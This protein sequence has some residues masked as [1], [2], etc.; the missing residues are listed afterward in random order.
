[1]SYPFVS[2]SNNFKIEVRTDFDFDQSNPL[3]FHYLFSYTIL[4][5][6]IGL[7]S[8]QLLS[9]KWFIRDGKGETRHVEGPGVIGQTPHFKPGQ[10]FEY[11]SFCPL[12]TLSGE[13]WGHFVMLSDDNETFKID[14]PIFKF[15]VPDDYIDQY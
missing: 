14:T 13:M 7:N 10:A 12:P 1:M 4:I 8:A 3:Q 9:R 5:T 15:K 2:I 11:S 6:N